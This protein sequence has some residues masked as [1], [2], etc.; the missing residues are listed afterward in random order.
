MAPLMLKQL[1]GILFLRLALNLCPMCEGQLNVSEIDA[2][3]ICKSCGRNGPNK[4]NG[5][6]AIHFRGCRGLTSRLFGF[7]RRYSSA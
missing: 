2:D 3:E 5:E 4:F 6:I 7:G 1:T